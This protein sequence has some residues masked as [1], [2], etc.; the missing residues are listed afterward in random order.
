MNKRTIDDF[1]FRGRRVLVRVDFNTPLQDGRVSDDTRVVETLPTLRKI[2][3]GGGRLILMSHLG[4]PKGERKPEYSLKPVAECLSALLGKPVVMADDCIG[5]TVRQQVEA[6]TDGDVLL[7][8]NLRYHKQEEKNDPDFARE[9]AGLGDVYVNDAFGTSHRA[10]ASTQGV[11]AFLKPALAGYLMK[12][13]IEFLGS[14]LATPRRPFV[15]VIG[16]AKVSSKIGVLEHLI[17]K[18]D[19]FIIGGGMAFTFLKALGHDIGKSL[20]EEDKID[21]AREIHAK[22]AAGGSPIVLPV[23]MV[24]AAE[25]KEGVAGTVYPVENLPADQA[26]FDI[27]PA[28]IELFKKTLNGAS[29]VVWNGPMGVFEIPPFHTGTEAIARAIAAMS[30]ATTIVGGGDSVAAV[31][32]FDLKR[33]M[34]HVSTGGGASLEMMEGRE[35]PGLASL[36][37]KE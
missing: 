33:S 16:G 15:A 5:D 3:D 28:S 37:D 13:E 32:K 6:L 30:D 4:R 35:L 31:E 34:T 29:L 9:L 17:G 8:E 23:D 25:L 2:L 22:A 21:L 10:H 36:T 7:L 19:R 14:A 27:G 1:D 26:G 20:L 24:C 18:V 11:T 12:K